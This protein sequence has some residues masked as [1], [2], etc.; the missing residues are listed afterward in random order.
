MGFPIKM[1]DE[2][3]KGGGEKFNHGNSK[4]KKE[5]K[6]R[7]LHRR[8]PRGKKKKKKRS[9]GRGKREAHGSA[10]PK[11]VSTR[12]GLRLIKVRWGRD[13]PRG[14]RGGGLAGKKEHDEGK[15][16]PKGEEKKRLPG[17]STTHQFLAVPS[18]KGKNIQECG[19]DGGN[20]FERN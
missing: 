20:I 2:K 8:N 13:G 7:F 17:R 6:S 19:E 11:E 9:T 10:G 12:D 14:K 4:K 18:I 3:G 1:R 16:C 5:G 15:T